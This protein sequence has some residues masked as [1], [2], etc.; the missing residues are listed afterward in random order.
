MHYK[1][2]CY[3]R[4]ISF[5]SNETSYPANLF[6]VLFLFCISFFGLFIASH[7]PCVASGVVLDSIGAVSSGRG[8]TN[9]PHADNGALIHDNP[10]ALVTMPSGKM[11]EFSSEFIYPEVRY[12]DAYDADYSKHEVFVIPAF[13]FVYKKTEDSRIAFGGGIFSQAGFGTEYRLEHNMTRSA[14]EGDLPVSFGNQ[15]YRSE[16][17]LIKLLASTSFKINESLSLGFSAG[18]SIQR[19]EF[20]MPYTFQTGALAGVSALGEMNTRNSYGFTYTMG[21]QYKISRNTIVGISYVSESRSTLEGDADIYLPD[22]VPESVLFNNRQANYDLEF[23]FEWPRSVGVGVLH[24]ISNS[25]RFSF[26]VLWYDWASA[27]DSLDIELT[28]GDNAEFDAALGKTLKD[29]FPIEWDSVFAFR[30]GYEYF[31]KGSSNDIIRC[32]YIYNENPI[33]RET[34]IPLIPGNSKHNFS[35]GYSHKWKKWE[36]DIASQY[37]LSEKDRVT[38]SDIVGGDFNDSSLKTK[39]YLLFLGAKYKF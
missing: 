30:F 7:R 32:G 27:F 36:F 24:K 5:R 35:V 29:S 19:V 22:T 3:L 31:V 37:L 4:R 2:R 8:G 26:D 13:S 14:M 11:L 18:P 17:S 38:S 15:V 28:D 12:E 21:V 9:I 1:E 10:A 20:E 33:S 16:A 25:H 6:F 23:E 39:A 34:Q